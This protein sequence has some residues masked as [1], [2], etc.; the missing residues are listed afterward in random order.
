[1]VSLCF[2]VYKYFSYIYYSD[3]IFYFLSRETSAIKVNNIASQI[4]NNVGAAVEATNSLPASARAPTVHYNRR[5]SK[6]RRLMDPMSIDSL[7]FRAPEVSSPSS[8][9]S[10]RGIIT[11]D[12]MDKQVAQDEK[13]SIDSTEVF[14]SLSRMV[15][16]LC[17]KNLFL[18]L[19]RAF[20][21]FLPSC[22]LL[23]FIRALQVCSLTFCP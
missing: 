13:V 4:A 10:A 12:A 18:P 1:M 3:P 8:G 23:P 11:E 5:N 15:A 9:V 19:L 14:A 6:R 16:V 20:E 17:E 7:T 2:L 22:S 21:M